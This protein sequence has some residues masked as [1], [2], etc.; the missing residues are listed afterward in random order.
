MLDIV[1]NERPRRFKR[2]SLQKR[3]IAP[4]PRDN[5]EGLMKTLDMTLRYRNNFD[6]THCL[7]NVLTPPLA[8]YRESNYL[9]FHPSDNGLI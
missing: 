2:R 7:G 1:E 8:E 5:I 6:R 9:G 4:L 3:Q